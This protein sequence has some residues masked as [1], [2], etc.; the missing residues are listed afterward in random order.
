MATETSALCGD[1]DRFTVAAFREGLYRS[2]DAADRAIVEL[3]SLSWAMVALA[4]ALVAARV[5]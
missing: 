1:I 4:L 5:F 2:I 3:S